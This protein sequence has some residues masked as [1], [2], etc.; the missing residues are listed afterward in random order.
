MIKKI[1]LFGG[2]GLALVAI[3]ATVMWF[4]L[5]PKASAS[6]TTST[7]TKTITVIANPPYEVGPTVSLQ[8]RVVN[9]ADPGASRYLKITTVLGFS[10]VLDKEATAKAQVS[11]REIILQDIL[12]RVVSDMTTAQLSTSQGKDLLKQTLI[13]QFSKVLTDLH[14]IDIFFP[15]FVMQ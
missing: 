9:L 3:T 5:A 14:L 11:S 1:A 10:P 13:S 6:H 7:I 12:T 15:D 2:I 4:L 8:T